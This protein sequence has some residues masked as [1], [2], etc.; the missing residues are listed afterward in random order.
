MLLTLES[1]YAITGI[2]IYIYL[3]PNKTSILPLLPKQ[4]WLAYITPQ[5]IRRLIKVTWR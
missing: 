2:Y 4:G 5:A 1:E 3:P